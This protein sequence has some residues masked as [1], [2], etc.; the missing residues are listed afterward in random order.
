[1]VPIEKRDLNRWK[2]NGSSY[3]C[4]ILGDANQRRLELKQGGERGYSNAFEHPKLE[5]VNS[6]VVKLAAVKASG[7]NRTKNKE[8][9]IDWRT[10]GTEAT[11]SLYHKVW[12]G[13]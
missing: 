5:S 10:I 4:S 1:M 11:N 6:G 8:E 3:P 7:E 13:G 12:E 2:L 9:A